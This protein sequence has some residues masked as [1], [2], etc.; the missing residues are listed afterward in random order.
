MC[1]S[2]G[3]ITEF[4]LLMKVGSFLAP[5]CR[6]ESYQLCSRRMLR[7]LQTVTR[8][9]RPNPSIQGRTLSPPGGASFVSHHGG[10]AN[11][12]SGVGHRGIPGTEN[13]QL[14]HRNR[15]AFTSPHRAQ[16]F[17]TM[18]VLILFAGS[19]AWEAAKKRIKE[20]LDFNR[21]L[22]WSSESTKKPIPRE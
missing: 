3:A 10:C 20:F 12:S 14:S 6:E 22:D 1:S 2:V 13:R 4:S 7:L 8:W 15:P 16:T 5:L 9:I 21:N 17:R 19:P 11:G 18:N